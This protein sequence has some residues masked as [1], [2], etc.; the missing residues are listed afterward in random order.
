MII[1][2]IYKWRQKIVWLLAI[3]LVIAVFLGQF[4]SGEEPNRGA[5]IDSSSRVLQQPKE[6]TVPTSSPDYGYLKSILEK[7]KHYY[8]GE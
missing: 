1:I 3:V 5:D 2:T 7:L 8:R 6:V 4:I